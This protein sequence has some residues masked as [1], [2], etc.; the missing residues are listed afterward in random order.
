MTIVYANFLKY[1]NISDKIPVPILIYYYV[2]YDVAE[3]FNILC[4]C[5]FI[6]HT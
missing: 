1:F 4:T 6:S 3:S 2:K 5:V